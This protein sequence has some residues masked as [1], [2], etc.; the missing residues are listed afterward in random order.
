[1][2]YEVNEVDGGD[3]S[4][5]IS[6][7]N[8]TIVVP[9]SVLIRGA[10]NFTVFGLSN[11][12]DTEF[13]QALS[14]KVAP[15]EFAASMKRIN[16]VLKKTLPMNM[17]WLLCGCLCCCCTLGCSMWPVVCLT[18]R[19]QHLIEKVLDWENSHLYHKLGLHWKLS[20]QRSD[21]NSMTEYVLLLEFI[22]KLPIHR[23][24]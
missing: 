20:K 11:K 22:P 1:M 16:G 21:S 24:D 2:I 19:T 4:A 23:P 12:F 10:G 17:K 15:E 9:D 7:S 3:N 14:A 18:K 6:D 8:Y 13:P 5:T